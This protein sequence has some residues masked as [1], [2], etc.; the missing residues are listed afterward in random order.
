[1]RCR[2]NKTLDGVLVGA[3]GALVLGLIDLVADRAGSSADLVANA[4]S[5]VALGLLLVRL[6]AGLS[7]LALDALADVV[8]GVGHRVDG[9]ADD[10]LLV[11]GQQ[12]LGAGSSRQ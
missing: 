10:A 12:W 4:T 9:L 6:L 2:S 11:K 7:R 8:G 1:V 5:G 3:G